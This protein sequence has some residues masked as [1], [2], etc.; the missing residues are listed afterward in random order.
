MNVPKEVVL[1]INLG[2]TCPSNKLT[3]KEQTYHQN[4]FV[5]ASHGQQEVH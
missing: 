3:S 5:G 1:G 4:T 2:R